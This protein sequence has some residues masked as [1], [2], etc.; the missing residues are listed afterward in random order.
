VYLTPDLKAFLQFG[1]E[2]RGEEAG[3]DSL[4]ES[5]ALPQPSSSTS[6][7]QLPE[8]R[9]E[10]R[11]DLLVTRPEHFGFPLTAPLPPA[12]GRTGGLSAI[13]GRCLTDRA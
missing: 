6:F 7:P 11:P 4:Q 8:R 2:R 3:H 12:R 5:T 13:K 1:G 10:Q 9:L